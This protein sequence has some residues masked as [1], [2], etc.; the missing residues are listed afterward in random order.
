MNFLTFSPISR[1]VFQNLIAVLMTSVSGH[2][3]THPSLVTFRKVYCLDAFEKMGFR[4]VN[5]HVWVTSRKDSD[6]IWR[7]ELLPLWH[8]EKIVRFHFLKW[9]QS[10]CNKEI[11]SEHPINPLHASHDCYLRDI[12]E[13]LEVFA[14][15]IRV[16]RNNESDMKIGLIYS[17]WG[18]SDWNERDYVGIWNVKMVLKHVRFPPIVRIYNRKQNL[19]LRKYLKEFLTVLILL[20]PYS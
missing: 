14:S 18:S 5:G 16:H 8:H 7:T 12:R 19:N 4:S 3:M 6:R 10:E 1:T 15:F 11:M 2:K 17:L 9:N 20:K 13:K